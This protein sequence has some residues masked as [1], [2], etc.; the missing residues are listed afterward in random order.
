MVTFREHPSKVLRPDSP[1]PM[2]CTLE[3]KLA[4]LRETGID[5]IVVLDFDEARAHE[6]AEDFVIRDLVGRL[7]VS[8]VVVGSN[9]RFGYERR[10]DV[11]M[12]EKMG[13]QYGFAA[14]GIELVLD[15]EHQSVVSST[16]IRA[17]I[18]DGEMLE[19]ERLLGRPYELRGSLGPRGQLVVDSELLVPPPGRYCVEITR[20]GQDHPIETSSETTVVIDN[21]G[22]ISLAPDSIPVPSDPLTVSFCG[23]REPVPEADL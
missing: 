17:L 23:D 10:G 18:R 22:V 13:Q 2:L 1:V 6:S 16:R 21:V 15:D 3:E 9:F 8:E 14:K 4:L 11:A 19:A 12:L 5:E 20:V 7:N